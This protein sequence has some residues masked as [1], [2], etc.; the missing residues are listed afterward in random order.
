MTTELTITSC[1]AANTFDVTAKIGRYLT[2]KLG[3][4]WDIAF[5]YISAPKADADGWSGNY[6]MAAAGEIDISWVCAATYAKLMH[7]SDR[8]IELLATPIFSDPAYQN[9]PVY[10]S[11]LVVPADSA[12]QT[13]ADLQGKRFTYNETVS[14]S[15][16][17]TVCSYLQSL[18]I[19]QGYFDTATASGGHIKSIQ[20]LAAGETD[21]AAIDSTVWHWYQ[22]EQPALC[23]QLRPI[24]LLPPY[25]GPPLIISHNVS[26]DLA[27]EI[28]TLLL[29]LHQTN[30]GTQLLRTGALAQFTTVDN[31]NYEAPLHAVR[32]GATIPL[33]P[34]VA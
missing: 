2:Q 27:Q 34:P 14:L 9:Q 17:H 11:Y 3:K 10:F 1:Q 31:A 15:G 8:K 22:T 29:E 7:Q 33:V 18:G 12:F 25:A 30:E 4:K 28:Q 26:R 24:A 13:F 19:E 20:I 21:C 16:H 23:A 6:E 5:R 32:M